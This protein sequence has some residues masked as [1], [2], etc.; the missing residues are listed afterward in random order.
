MIK[1]LDKK[2]LEFDLMIQIQTDPHGMPIENA[3]IPV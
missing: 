1:T 2:E 3:A